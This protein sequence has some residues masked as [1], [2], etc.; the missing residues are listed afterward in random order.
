SFSGEPL[1]PLLAE[2]ANA[3]AKGAL[4]PEH[5]EVIRSFADK[6]P[7]WVD[8]ITREQ[9]EATLVHI[10]G[11][12][13]PEVLRKDAVKLATA[14]DQDGPAPD[15][16]ERA[17]KREI[18]LGPQGPDG[19][20]R[21][22]GW[23]DPQGRAT[24][25]PALAKLAA[26]GMCNPEDCEPCTSGTPSQAQIDGDTRSLGQRQHDAFVAIGRTGLASG[27]LGQHNGLPVTVIVSTTVQ[28]L[29][30]AAGSGVSA[31]GTLVPMADLI[32][33]ASHAVHYLVVY[34]KHTREPLYLGRTKRLASVGQRIVL[35]ARDRGCTKPG[36]T[37]P[38]Y[39]T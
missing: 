39:G 10:A 8:P 25:E 32:R 36:C 38:G 3:R 2:T 22:T 4:G 37:V 6:L 9:A 15:D 29:E 7:G 19:M 13:G 31:G 14:I 28:D 35:H 17:R 20:S 11:L 33:M 21:I 12:T 16:R 1:A 18:H 23:L 26:P 27:E 34:D 30:K 24:W 5:V